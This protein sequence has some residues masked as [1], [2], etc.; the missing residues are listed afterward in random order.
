[1]NIRPV[2]LE[3][4]LATLQGWWA[5]HKALPVPEFFLQG[6]EGFFCEAGGVDIA[7]AFVYLGLACKFAVVEYITTNPACSNS[8]SSLEAVYSLLAHA[9]KIARENG[10]RSILSMIAPGSSE[11]RI[12]GKVGYV[13]SSGVSHRMWGKELKEG[14]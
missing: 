5:A 1:V 13:T 12:M 2:V 3:R 6:A 7:V 9:E 10:C 8:R 14:A 11:E 4:D